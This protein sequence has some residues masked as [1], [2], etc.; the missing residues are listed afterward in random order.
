MSTDDSTTQAGGIVWVC[1]LQAVRQYDCYLYLIDGATEP[2]TEWTTDK[3][4]LA[5]GRDI[6]IYIDRY[7]VHI[8]ST[9]IY[10]SIRGENFEQHDF[11]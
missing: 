3:A 2:L 8:C 4:F 10:L 9:C 5:S 7:H 11:G 6:S 1:Q